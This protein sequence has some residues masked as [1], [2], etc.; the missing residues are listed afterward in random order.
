MAKAIKNVIVWRVSYC[1]FRILLLLICI[2]WIGMKRKRNIRKSEYTRKRDIIYIYWLM[3]KNEYFKNGWTSVGNKE[4]GEGEKRREEN[5][6]EQ[7]G[8]WGKSTA[9]VFVRN[10][11]TYNFTNW[12]EILWK[13]SWQIFPLN[14]LLRLATIHPKIFSLI[15]QNPEI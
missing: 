6:K 11:T 13:Q 3:R 12:S 8:K 4:H 2:V 7:K 1:C 10:V 14:K 5:K 9:H 15:S